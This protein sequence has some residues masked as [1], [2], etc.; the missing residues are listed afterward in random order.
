MP[1]YAKECWRQYLEHRSAS[2]LVQCVYE[3]SVIEAEKRGTKRLVPR[4]TEAL[5]KLAQFKEQ[6]VFIELSDIVDSAGIETK[7]GTKGLYPWLKKYGADVLEHEPGTTAYRIKD[8]FYGAMLSLFP[9][10][11][12]LASTLDIMRLQG[13]GK[14]IW[15]GLDA[16]DYV[17]RERAAWAG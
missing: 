4:A 11:N 6:Q 14:E 9:D 12:S 10:A 15:A 7:A 1:E 5:V 17:D 16:Q 13:L 2:R 3:Q 8:E